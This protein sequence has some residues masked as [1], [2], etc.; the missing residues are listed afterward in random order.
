M[1]SGNQFNP[2]STGARYVER[3]PTVA[4]PPVSSDSDRIGFKKSFIY[5]FVG[6]L[7]FSIIVSLA[8]KQF[9]LLLKYLDLKINNFISKGIP[10]C[11]MDFSRSYSKIFQWCFIFA[12]RI[13][14]DKKCLSLLFNNWFCDGHT[15]VH[16]LSF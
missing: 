4:Q 13:Q 2:N 7:R 3:P 14:F 9:F 1:S 5:S 8:K 15:F 16:S 11:R 10:T 12:A 6:I